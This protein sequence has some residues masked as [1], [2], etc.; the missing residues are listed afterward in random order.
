MDADEAV[1]DTASSDDVDGGRAAPEPVD[2]AWSLAGVGAGQAVFV[3][4]HG[5][6][7]GGGDPGRGARRWPSCRA[8]FRGADLER[9]GADAVYR[10]VAELLDRLDDSPFR[11][12]AA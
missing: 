6:G 2:R 1:R 7:H 4:R 9:A 12:P 10:D 5:V 3:G 8:V 11:S